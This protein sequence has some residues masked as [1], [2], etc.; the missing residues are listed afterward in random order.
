MQNR[1][2]FAC[3]NSHHVTIL[4]HVKVFDTYSFT[5]PTYFIT[6]LY[7]FYSNKTRLLWSEPSQCQFGDEAEITNLVTTIHC[8]IRPLACL[9]SGNNKYDA[10]VQL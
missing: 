9:T 4:K 2:T 6:L 3:Y 8:I 7:L 5:F 10:M 1:Y